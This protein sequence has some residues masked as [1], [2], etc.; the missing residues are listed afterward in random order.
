MTSSINRS[1]PPRWALSGTCSH[2]GINPPRAGLIW[3]RRGCFE[4]QFAPE[5]TVGSE[6]LRDPS[7]AVS[8]QILERGKVGWWA[9][10]LSLCVDLQR[11]FN[12]FNFNMS[13]T[14][15]KIV[16]SLTVGSL[17]D[18]CWRKHVWPISAQSKCI[19]YI[20]I[21]TKIRVYILN[22]LSIFHK[23]LI[24]L[25]LWYC[26][27]FENT[28]SKHTFTHTTLKYKFEVLLLEYFHCMLF[29]ISEENT[30]FYTTFI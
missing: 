19:Q 20:M 14:F 23:K 11:D 24:L 10:V 21:L 4:H 8:L 3:E 25:F 29:Y 30:A 5:S 12:A 7:D 13:N 22:I 15:N 9:L 26:S 28:T 6:V 17:P 16:S 2:G 1:Q 27:E 18:V